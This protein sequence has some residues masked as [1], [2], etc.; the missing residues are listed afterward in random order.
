MVAYNNQDDV[1]AAFA[2]LAHLLD[3]DRPRQGGCSNCHST[4]LERCANVGMVLHYCTVCRDCGAVQTE[5]FGQLDESYYTSNRTTSNYKRIHHWHERISQFLL[6]ESAIPNEHFLQIAERL[7][8]GSHPIVNKDV[9]RGVLRSLNMQIYI[10]K[11]LQIIQRITQVEPPK[12]GGELLRTLDDMF[13]ELQTPFTNYKADKRKNFLNYNYVFC[14][15]FQKIDCSQFSM[16]F[17]LIKSRAKLKVLDEM[18]AQ[19]VS[20]V[21]WP[22]TPLQIVPSFAVQLESPD[23]QLQRIRQQVAFAVPVET[24]TVLGKR[25][26]RKSDLH[27]LRELDRQK[28]QARR[29]SA[30]PEPVPQRL[31]W[32]RKH[33]PYASAREP[34]P[35]RRLLPLRRPV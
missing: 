26:F 35:L 2:D 22:I 32:T 11:W 34:Q 7:C 12:P 9:I 19:M 3:E 13:Q 23:V 8:D 25:V 28:E 1:D 4:N 33:L 16:F 20:A 6:C 27:L 21:G 31:G 30:P 29:R 17:P 18:W 5:G 24:H 14:R 15:L 10:E